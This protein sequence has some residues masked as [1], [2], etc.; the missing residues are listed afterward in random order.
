MTLGIAFGMF[1][2]ILVSVIVVGGVFLGNRKLKSKNGNKKEPNASIHP[3]KTYVK[4]YL[5]KNRCKCRYLFG[6]K[7]WH[8]YNICRPYKTPNY[9]SKM[10]FEFDDWSSSESDRLKVLTN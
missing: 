5:S 8:F 9:D 1:D 10:S 6:L 3:I 4:K 2:L 7:K